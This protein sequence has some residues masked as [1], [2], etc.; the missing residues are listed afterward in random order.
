MACAYNPVSARCTGGKIPAPTNDPIA[1]EN[2]YLGRRLVLGLGTGNVDRDLRDLKDRRASG[3]NRWRYVLSEPRAP[4][5][6]PFSVL[7]PARLLAR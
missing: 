6:G 1:E 4:H 7:P 3:G 5:Q 2:R